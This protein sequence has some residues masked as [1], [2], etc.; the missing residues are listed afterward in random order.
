[1]ENLFLYGATFAVLYCFYVLGRSVLNFDLL[2][3]NLFRPVVAQAK[4]WL[5]NLFKRK[6][7]LKR[8][9]RVKIVN[10]KV[11]FVTLSH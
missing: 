4:T 2:P 8:K 7:F 10:V 3:K 6:H 5:K 1:M 9:D 11:Y